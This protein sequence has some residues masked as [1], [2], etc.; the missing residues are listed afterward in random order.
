MMAQ[1]PAVF[2]K[3]VAASIT[4]GCAV[5]SEFFPA[6]RGEKTVG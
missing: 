5:G 3:T 6:A 4:R 2:E 1:R